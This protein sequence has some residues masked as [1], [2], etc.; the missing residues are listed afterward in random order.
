MQA[1]ATDFYGHPTGKAPD[2]GAIEYGQFAQ[3]L[4][5]SAPPSLLVS[6]SWLRKHGWKVSVQLKFTGV[7]ALR[8]R[9]LLRSRPVLTRTAPVSGA[10]ARPS[11]VVPS[12]ARTASQLRLEFRGTSPD[13]RALVRTTILHLAA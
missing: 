2:I 4:G 8:L 9:V 1:R 5:L 6:R 13:G 11:F 12:A 10:A 7:T 3:P